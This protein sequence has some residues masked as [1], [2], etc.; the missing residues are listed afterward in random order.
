M[1]KMRTK[2]FI[3]I[4][5]LVLLLNGVGGYLYYSSQKSMEQYNLLLQRFF[6]LNKIS[7]NT[8]DAYQELQSYFVDHSPKLFET[9]QE[10]HHELLDNQERL[11]LINHDNNHLML[12]NYRHMI[13]S[14][15]N[16]CAM[17]IHA[18][19]EG[20]INLYSEHLAESGKIAGFIKDTTL[21]LINSELTDYQR[22]YHTMNQKNR[23]F[24]YMGISIFI[25]TLLFCTLF[26]IWFSG[27]MSRPIRRLE[28]AAKDIAKGKFDGDDVVVETRD[29]FRFLT[30]TFNH[31]KNNTQRLV[32]EIKEKS[33]LDRLLK[34]MELKSLQNQMNP[35]FL[36]NTLNVVSKTA[37][38]EG[39]DKTSELIAATAALFRHNL[40]NLDEPVMLS[41]EVKIIKDYFFI[42]ATRFG[43][44]LVLEMDVAPDCLDHY[45]PGM[46]LQP[47]VENAF[48]HG[49]EPYEGQGKIELVIRQMAGR[50]LIDIADNGVGMSKQTI[51]RIYKKENQSD[52]PNNKSHS[53]GL[54]LNN[55][56]RRLDLFYKEN[57]LLN[58]HSNG[59]KGTR[60]I[61][62]LPLSERRKMSHV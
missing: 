47:I 54:G 15:I 35:H 57:N 52:R 8:E 42:L 3:F 59:K 44:R 51:D 17:A 46:I 32:E 39:A 60:I 25:T 7:Q 58:I 43:D 31:M 11:I 55:V 36:F 13:N 28:A 18:F 34:E 26:T 24:E 23:Y 14:F 10:S 40:G 48:I 37:Y 29:E 21:A 9:Y 49:I 12:T 22:F 2:L 45:V 62:S 20:N 19:R 53:T 33:E 56:I 5:V 16:E 4:M 61:L 30:D 38:L 6:L 1:I 50:L 27:G 41:K